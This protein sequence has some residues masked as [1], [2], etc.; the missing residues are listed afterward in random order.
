MTLPGPKSS[1]PPLPRRGISIMK[2]SKN[3]FLAVATMVGTVIGAG[4]FT[5]PIIVAKAGI[6]PFLVFLAGLAILQL[7][8]HEM[9]ASVVVATPGAHRIPGYVE[10]YLGKKYKKIVS[11][12]CLLGGYGA[13]LAYIILG[14]IFA[15][16]ILYPFLGGSVVIYSFVLFAL[17]AFIVLLGLKAIAK[18]E[19]ILTLLLLVVA[20]LITWKCFNNF[21]IGHISLTDWRISLLL[22]GPVFFSLSGDVAVP[23]VCRLLN[24]E[25]NKIKSAIFWGTAIPALVTGL[26]VIAVAGATG[27]A[28]T[29]DTLTGLNNIFDSWI[30][31][32]ALI[33]GVINIFT[34]FLTSLQSVKEIYWWDF[35]I[36]HFYSWL[37]AAAV[38]LFLFVIGVQN[39]TAVVSLS[40][41]ITGGAIGII[42]IILARAVSLD[43]KK[44]PLFKFNISTPVA[45]VLSVFFLAGLLFEFAAY[46][47]FL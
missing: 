32:F 44:K 18:S 15:H 42:M 17:E 12:V 41:A 33:F 9:Y 11:F 3:Y 37:L 34:S 25:K 38:P 8:F 40:G 45:L 36:D 16:D 21:D 2:F 43:P 29:A 22:Y 1:G 39:V 26:F 13:L 23:E 27:S 35:K 20:G 4:I 46:F 24:K 5:L 6:I 28:T 47:K 30:V 7:L 14:G 31:Y 10:I 19:F